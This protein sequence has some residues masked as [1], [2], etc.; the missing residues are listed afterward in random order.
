MA[1]TRIGLIGTGVVGRQRIKAITARRDA[2]LVGTAG[3]GPTIG[4]IHFESAAGLLRR[5][6]LDAIVYAGPAQD[7]ARV[8]GA[9]LQRGFHVLSARPPGLSVEDVINLRQA[10]T[11]SGGKVL[12]FSF[13]LHYHGSVITAKALARGGGFGRLV[14]MRAVYSTIR[15]PKLSTRGGVL[16]DKGMQVL[17]L[18]QNFCGPFVE[19]KSLISSDLWG[20]PGA[21]DNA[22]ALLRTHEGVVGQI[23]ASATWWRETFRL[24][25]G[26]ERGYI[27]LEGLTGGDDGLSPEMLITGRTKA[28]P[29]G[30]MLPNPEE[31]IREFKVNN[32]LE[33]ELADFLHAMRGRGPVT[34]G[35]SQQ[36]FDAMNIVQRI[37]ADD[38]TWMPVA[39]QAAE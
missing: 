20:Q 10:E 27:W 38:Q 19:V 2:L 25:L 32:A 18:M 7:T 30:H 24:E 15:E 23:H 33:L 26:F 12:Q 1:A 36:A 11:N 3:P 34:V 21:D 8:V 5:A 28:G 6:D 9:A 17:D 35:S 14:N 29:D 16:F 31:D 37:Y 39:A 22:F 4:V 13:P